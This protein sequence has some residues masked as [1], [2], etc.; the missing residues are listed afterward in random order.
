V[1]VEEFNRTLVSQVPWSDFQRGIEVFSEKSDLLPFEEA[2]LYGHNAVQALLG[3]L[4]HRSEVRFMHETATLQ[5]YVLSAFH[6]ESGAALCQRHYGVDGFFTPIGW[7]SYAE[8][9]LRRMVNPYLQDRV[10]RVVRDPRR[11]L[12]WNDRIIGTMRIALEH[13]IKP[14]RFAAGAAVATELLF[15]NAST[16]CVQ[17]ALS[18]MWSVDARS[19]ERSTLRASYIVK[20]RTSLIC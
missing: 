10:E 4:A 19:Q 20:A 16:M 5:D 7:A 6:E 12:A 2:K 9:L 11:K 18:E 15:A 8:D 14:T 17:N 1:L 3:Y 13:N